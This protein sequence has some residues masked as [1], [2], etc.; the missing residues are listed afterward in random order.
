MKKLQDDAPRCGENNSVHSENCS[1]CNQILDYKRLMDEIDKKK[2]MVN[3]INKLNEQ[4]SHLISG[5]DGCYFKDG[6]STPIYQTE[7]WQNQLK[8]IIRGKYEAIRY[9]YE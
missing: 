6:K 5:F 9:E 4:F 1:R 2:N 7:E 3:E 8:K